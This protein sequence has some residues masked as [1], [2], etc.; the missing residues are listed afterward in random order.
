MATTTR[1]TTRRKTAKATPKKTITA[2]VA[3][4]KLPPTFNAKTMFGV[5][6]I[7]LTALC[8]CVGKHVPSGTRKSALG[9][10]PVMS[11]RLTESCG[12]HN[13]WHLENVTPGCIERFP[14]E[15]VMLP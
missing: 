8:G 1:A 3:E 5:D 6:R 13:R 7:H 11:L 15:L 12:G 4:E 10:Y 9:D 14:P 2:V